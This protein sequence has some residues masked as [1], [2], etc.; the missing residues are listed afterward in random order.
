MAP[1]DYFD[2]IRC[3]NLDSATERWQKME[4]RFAKLGI[5]SRVRR[6]SAV[7]TPGNHHVG[8]ALSHRRIVE[9]AKALGHRSVLVFEDDALFLDSTLQVLALA[10]EELPNVEWTLCFLGGFRWTGELEPEPGCQHWSRAENVTCTHAIAYSERFYDRLLA[11]LPGDFAGM[12]DWVEK[13]AGIDQHLRHI[14]N[15]VLTRPPV[16]AQPFML[17]Y[18]DPADQFHFTI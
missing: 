1:F 17:P 10:V 3:I 7:P 16:S 11:E 4:T 2:D 5:A 18:E 13:N 9:E 6:F 8:C 12:H 14:E 15:A